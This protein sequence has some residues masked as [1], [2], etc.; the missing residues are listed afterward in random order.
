MIK[1]DFMYSFDSK[2]RVRYYETDKMGVVHHSNYVRYY[3]Y[4][5]TEMMIYLGFSYGTMEKEGIMMPVISVSSKYIKPAYYEDELV[6]RVA[7][8]D[9]PGA[10][11]RFFYEIFN[12]HGDLINTGETV[13]SFTSTVTNRPCR[14]PKRL[15][16]ILKEII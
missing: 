6:I 11:M 10:K 7:L 8:K 16:D 1:H 14:P 2:L 13:L 3:E 9:L 15:T 4:A 12:Q 5:R